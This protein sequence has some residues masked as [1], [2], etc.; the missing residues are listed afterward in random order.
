MRLVFPDI[1]DV[2]RNLLTSQQ[3][4]A[5]MYY[6]DQHLTQAEAAGRMIITEQA[7][8][9]LLQ[10]AYRRINGIPDPEQVRSLVGIDESEIVAMV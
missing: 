7:V 6:H 10:R 9:R 2:R 8:G 1:H 5:V 3:E 4:R